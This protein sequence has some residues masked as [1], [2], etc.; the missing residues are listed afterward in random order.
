MSSIK[1]L[2][3]KH[4]QKYFLTKN[5]EENETLCNC[6]TKNKF[7]LNN[8]CFVEYVIYKATITSKN[9]TKNHL[10]STGGTFNKR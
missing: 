8:K 6:Q 2:I 5:D 4:N 1:K 3:Q 9:Q 7:F 10:G